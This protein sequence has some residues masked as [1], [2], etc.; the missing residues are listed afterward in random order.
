MKARFVSVS[1][2][3]IA[4]CSSGT[5]VVKV[6]ERPAAGRAP[7]ST[8]L[9]V[10]VHDDRAIRRQFE[11]AL[12]QALSRDTTRAVPS[13]GAMDAAKALDAN[14]VR[15][16]IEATGAD[17]VLITRLLDV[18]ARSDVELGRASAAAE[19]RHDITMIDFFRYDYVEYPDPLSITTVHTVI[20]ATDL[21]DVGD[22]S[23][24][25]GVESTAFEKETATEV[26]EAISSGIRAQLARDGLIR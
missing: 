15:A 4:A 11:D 16:A 7:Y 10:G 23:K 20:C 19:R 25:W 13:S 17:G 22:T 12:A 14:A 8:I 26:I 24:V 9:V 3:A 21:Y 1:L 6:Y 2:C 5:T 18:R